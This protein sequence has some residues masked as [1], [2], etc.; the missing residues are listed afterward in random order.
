MKTSSTNILSRGSTSR[1]KYCRALITFGDFDQRA[2]YNWDEL[3]Y[4][5]TKVWLQQ[6]KNLIQNKYFDGKMEDKH[7]IKLRHAEKFKWSLENV[8]P[9]QLIQQ[10]KR[11]WKNSILNLHAYF[12]E[13]RSEA[14]ESVTVTI[15]F[16]SG[17]EVWKVSKLSEE[18]MTRAFM[19]K[20]I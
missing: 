5:Y 18:R 1:T 11:T 2:N 17:L 14:W 8:E 9:M 10:Q 12:R 16:R 15:Y 7:N 20:T 13:V 6:I 19:D 3:I 4:S